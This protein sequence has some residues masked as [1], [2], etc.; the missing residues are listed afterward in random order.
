MSP[1]SPRAEREFPRRR[2]EIGAAMELKP[3]HPVHERVFAGMESEQSIDRTD[4]TA[5]RG[6]TPGHTGIGGEDEACVSSAVG[7]PSSVDRR[8]VGH[9]VGHQGPSLFG[10]DGQDSLVVLALPSAFDGGD[11]IVTG[12]T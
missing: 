7:G 9:V 5:D 12:L 11:D 4:E 3:V 10:T 8:E 2:L 6:S 1:A